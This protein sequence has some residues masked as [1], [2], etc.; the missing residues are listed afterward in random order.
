LAVLAE[1]NDEAGREH[2]AR[3]W[4]SGEQGVVRELGCELGDCA[5]EALD[6][7]SVTLSCST[8]VS[9]CNV[10]GPMTAGSSVSAVA[11]LTAWMRASMR[12]R[13]RT[14]CSWKKRSRVAPTSYPQPGTAEPLALGHCRGTTN[15][16][17][18]PSAE[19]RIRR[20]SIPVGQ[21]RR[22]RPWN[23]TANAVEEARFG[24]ENE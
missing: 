20:R 7:S 18:V 6:A 19:P 24:F 10:Q 1:G 8:R 11:L 23:E 5:I 13:R 3:T 21:N 2:R 4:Q 22:D 9:A 14:R 17:R 15:Q 16:G 12:C